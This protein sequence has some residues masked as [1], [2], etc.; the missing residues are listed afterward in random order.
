MSARVVR[1]WPANSVIARQAVFLALDGEAEKA[2]AAL[3][4]ALRSYPGQREATLYIL[5]QA[6][7]ADPAA[8]EPLLAMSKRAKAAP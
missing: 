5:R 4:R 7:P 1:Y 8:I 3:G 6:Y 2:R